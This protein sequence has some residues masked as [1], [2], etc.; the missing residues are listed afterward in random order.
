MRP[1]QQALLGKPFELNEHKFKFKNVYLSKSAIRRR[2]YL[3][4]PQ[5][6]LTEPEFVCKDEDVVILR[7]GLTVC[8]VTRYQIGSGLI[9]RKDEAGKVLEGYS[10]AQNYAK[11][12]K[13]AASDILSRAAVEFNVGAYLKDLDKADKPKDMD[14]LKRLLAKLNAA[15]PT[16]WSQTGGRER[17]SEMLK[18]LGLEWKGVNSAIEKDRTLTV[19]SE[20][21][22]TESEFMKRLVELVTV[23]AMPK[24]SDIVASAGV[25]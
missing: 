11:A 14:D 3:A 2:L 21:S 1:D 24:Y 13:A 22:L 10:L 25:Q 7:G 4:D 23:P 20:T 15:E 17:V 18:L 9:Q 6:K 19:L 8:G 16:H 5:W 12:Y